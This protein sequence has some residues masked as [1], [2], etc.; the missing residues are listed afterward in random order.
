MPYD[1]ILKPFAC[2]ACLSEFEF[3]LFRCDGKSSGYPKFSLTVLKTV[4]GKSIR[5]HPF[6]ITRAVK[7]ISVV[8]KPSDQQVFVF[9]L[10]EKMKT[11]S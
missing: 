4:C 8:K 2:N 7:D 3:D 9:L 5:G 11:K 10:R 6:E 1:N